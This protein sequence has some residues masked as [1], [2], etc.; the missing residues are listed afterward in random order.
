MSPHPEGTYDKA[1]VPP[2]AHPEL[3]LRDHMALAVPRGPI[4]VQWG[5]AVCGPQPPQ[6]D[7]LKLMRWWADVEAAH[8]YT[9]A[10]AMLRA[11]HVKMFDHI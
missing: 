3:T 11:R 2:K 10:D 8:R 7:P 1:G 4:P 9:Y 5:T 6:S